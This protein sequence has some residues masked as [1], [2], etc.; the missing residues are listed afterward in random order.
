MCCAVFCFY[1][2]EEMQEERKLRVR[3]ARPAIFDAVADR[4]R[5][6]CFKERQRRVLPLE[7][8]FQL[9]GYRWSA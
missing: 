5:S 3:V 8:D 9:L 7:I 6:L 2:S 4:S 1:D